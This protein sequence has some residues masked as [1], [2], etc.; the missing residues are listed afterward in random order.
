L[1]PVTILALD[2]NGIDVSGIRYMGEEKDHPS[3][4]ELRPLEGMSRF[5]L[6]IRE[7]VAAKMDVK[8][9][10]LGKQGSQRH[11]YARRHYYRW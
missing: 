10:W 3:Q 7:A 1:G 9:R 4:C 2:R 8:Q 6:N 5:L 11:Y